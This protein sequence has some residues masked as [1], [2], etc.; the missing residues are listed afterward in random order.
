[1]GFLD[2]AG[3]FMQYDDMMEFSFGKWGE[4]NG[5]DNFFGAGFKSVNVGETQISGIEFSISG[6]G[7]INNDITIN[8]LA[9]YTYIQPI[10][11]NPNTVYDT[12]EG[13]S[14]LEVF[15]N[16]EYQDPQYISDVTYNNSSSDPSVLKY[17]YKHLAKIDAE[18]NYKKISLGGSFRYNDFMRNI[19]AIFTDKTINEG[20]EGVIDPIIP[21]INDA[22]EKFKGGDVIID[23]RVGYQVNN[24]F[25]FGFVVN[26]LLNREYMSRP[27][28]MMPPR[29]FAMQ[30]AIKI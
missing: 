27:A 17:R 5:S 3:F 20:Y 6:Q 25:R 23:T 18:L 26:N 2:L 1:M 28:N 29:T 22:R 8:L 16:G 30:L 13:S 12:Y 24:M 10:S 4:D 15:A 21:G 14:L 11:L 7:K 9:G 19:D